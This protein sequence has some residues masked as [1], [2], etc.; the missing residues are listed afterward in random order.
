MNSES[1]ISLAFEFEE[2]RSLFSDEAYAAVGRALTFATR[3][4]ANCR[5]LAAMDGFV[6]IIRNRPIG[7]ASEDFDEALARFAAEYWEVRRLRHH[8]QSITLRYKLPPDLRRVIQ[9]GRKARNI[10]AHEMTL[11]IPI[12]VETDLGRRGI[13]GRLRELTRAL[14][15]ADRIVVLLIHVEND[16]PLPSIDRYDTYVTRAEVWVCEIESQE[17]C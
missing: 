4:E 7:P 6:Q 5:A 15:E 17:R 3:F 13:L 14:A 11:G 9:A 2:T 1:G 16:D 12:E 10:V 8:A